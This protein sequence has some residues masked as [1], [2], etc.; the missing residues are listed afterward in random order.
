MAGLSEMVCWSGTSCF[1]APSSISRVASVAGTLYTVC[2]S[3]VMRSRTSEG[4]IFAAILLAANLGLRTLMRV[5]TEASSSSG[6]GPLSI[7]GV[8]S[9][10][11]GGVNG[12]VGSG[13]GGTCGAGVRGV[14]M[15]AIFLLRSRFGW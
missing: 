11:M 6:S 2:C 13:G 8:T 3:T 15:L 1:L 14:R 12:A 4:V 7:D 5:E 9:A 10:V